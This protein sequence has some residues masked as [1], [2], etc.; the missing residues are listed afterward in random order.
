MKKEQLFVKS[1]L[2]IL[3]K[4]AWQEETNLAWGD[5]LHRFKKFH[6]QLTSVTV[7]IWLYQTRRSFK[8]GEM[9]R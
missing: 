2:G 8:G 1:L 6:E 5:S 4:E 3:E 7:R 9:I